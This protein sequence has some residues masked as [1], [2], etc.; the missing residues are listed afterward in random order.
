MNLTGRRT[1]ITA[2]V[3]FV[4]AVLQFFNV[5]SWDTE[6]FQTVIAGLGAIA[7]VFLR[8]SVTGK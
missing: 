8:A 3:I 1:Y 6:T 2:G 7:A 4:V 5:I